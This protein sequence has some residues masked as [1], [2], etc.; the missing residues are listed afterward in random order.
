LLADEFIAQFS[1]DGKQVGQ[2]S[3]SILD[4]S[5]ALKN[6]FRCLDTGE[7]VHQNDLGQNLLEVKAELGNH[8]MVLLN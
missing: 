2:E 6:I 5:L 7:H 4:R 1:V 8:L 3:D